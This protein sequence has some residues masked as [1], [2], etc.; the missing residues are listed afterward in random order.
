MKVF[1]A[2]LAIAA[3]ASASQSLRASKSAFVRD[4]RSEEPLTDM[5]ARELFVEYTDEFNKLYHL[6][7]IAS[8]YEAFVK[9]VEHI[10]AHNADHDAGLHT[11]T[12]GLN[13][14]ADMT[15]EEFRAQ[16]NNY[17]GTQE[18]KKNNTTMGVISGESA[19]SVADEMDWTAKGAVTGVKDQDICG[20]CWSFS[21]TGALEGAWQIKTGNLVSMSEQNL[22]DCVADGE[23]TCDYGGNAAVAIDYVTSHGIAGEEAYPY[24]ATSGH[25][26][27]SIESVA[28][29][30]GYDMVEENSEDALKVAASQ[31]PVAV[32]IDASH[33]SFQLYHGGVYHEP[34]CSSTEL[35]HGVLVTGYG[36]LSGDDY[37]SV[38]NSWGTGWGNDGY[39]WM[40]RNANN[41]CGIASNAVVPH[42]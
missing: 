31:Q 10:R 34:Q 17:V 39:I 21:T 19:H 40:A 22:V 3:V 5:E 23:F 16:K 35:D 9:N 41:H 18:R 24:T 42:A 11:F 4:I 28:S 1:V 33:F 37:W 7:E 13:E 8:K 26:C 2:S 12:L 14:Y 25:E 36:S 6:S 27:Q 32:A 29:F 38:K 30:T 20:S 15:N